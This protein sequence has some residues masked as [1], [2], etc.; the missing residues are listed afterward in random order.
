MIDLN[1]QITSFKFRILNCELNVSSRSNCLLIALL[2]LSISLYYERNYLC[3]FLA[4]E[5]KI[6]NFLADFPVDIGE[7]FKILHY[8]YFSFK[9]SV[10][11][12]ET[13]LYKAFGNYRQFI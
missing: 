4:L 7:F 5:N 2:G 1:V 11:T 8:R 13:F 12:R 9:F 3:F 6:I 10:L